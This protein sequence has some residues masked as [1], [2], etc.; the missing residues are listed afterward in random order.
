MGLQSYQ[1]NNKK[2]RKTKITVDFKDSVK[3]SSFLIH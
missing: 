2:E 1:E 3:R